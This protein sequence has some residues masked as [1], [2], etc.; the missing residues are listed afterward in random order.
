MIIEMIMPQMG[1]SVV[2]G[3]ITKWLKNPGEKVQE[4]ETLLEISTDKVD[5]EIPSPKAGVLVK[6]LV[7]EGQTVP[8]GTKIALI[9]TEG[10]EGKVLT[11]APKEATSASPAFPSIA[12]EEKSANKPVPAPTIQASD[13]FYSPLVKNIA[14]VENVSF[15]ELERLPGTGS[16]GRVTKND[17]LAYL[18]QKRNKQTEAIAP[19]KGTSSEVEAIAEKTSAVRVSQS[20]VDQVIEMDHIRR[21]IAEHMVLSKKVSPHVNTIAEADMTPI[22]KYR[23]SMKETFKKVEGINLTYTAFFIQA[24][25]RA[26]RDFPGVNASVDGTKIILKG[27]INVGMAVA[28]PDGNL[29]VPILKNADQLNLVGIAHLIDDLTGRARQKKL[30]PDEVS[31]GTFTVTNMGTFGSLFGTPI[32]NQPQV[33]ILGIGAIKK[34]VMVVEDDNIAIRSMVYINHAYDHR[35]VD[36]SLGGMFLQRVVKYLEEFKP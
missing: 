17:I 23:E 33:G 19:K 6:I 12:K 11:D 36:G 1:E 26:L 9:D 8:V 28:L 27:N 20:G 22:V 32:I 14:K 7:A 15:E 34:R 5:S 13:R 18:E 24:T 31:G 30:K 4:K 2:E 16:E 3:T 10:V 21:K 25:A 35:V 29:I